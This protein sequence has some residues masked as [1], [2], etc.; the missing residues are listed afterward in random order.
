MKVLIFILLL[1]ILF[2]IKNF[3][4]SLVIFLMYLVVKIFCAVT[5]E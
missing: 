3:Y 4:V 5:G 2:L 1:V